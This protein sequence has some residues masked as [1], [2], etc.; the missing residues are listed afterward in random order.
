MGAMGLQRKPGY[1]SIQTAVGGNLKKG[2][3]VEAC[4]KGPLDKVS[5]QVRQAAV[6]AGGMVA[7]ARNPAPTR[8]VREN[9]APGAIRMAV[10]LGN[11]LLQRRRSGA[12]RA[13]EEISRFI[14]AAL[15][16]D[17]K[18]DRVTLKSEG[19]LDAGKVELR[20]RDS[21]YELTF[22]NEYMTLERDGSRLATFPDLMMAFDLETAEPLISAQIRPGAEVVIIAVPRRRLILGAGMRDQVLLERVEKAIGKNM[23]R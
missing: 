11:R 21:R 23:R 16:I 14:G 19:G 20:A 3:R 22:W 12:R 10:Q 2:N 18:V 1:V 9:A 5:R 17:G 15:T 8:W 7:V 6:K 13:V 4:Y